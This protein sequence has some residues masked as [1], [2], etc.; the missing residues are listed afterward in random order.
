MNPTSKP[1]EE[2]RIEEFRQLFARQSVVQQYGRN[3]VLGLSAR[4]SRGAER[5]AGWLERPVV[6]LLT[7]C[8]TLVMLLAL[9][10]SSPAGSPKVSADLNPTPASI[11]I[12]QSVAEPVVEPAPPEEAVIEAAV[13][14]TKASFIIRV[15][16]FRNPLNAE[17]I[18]QALRGQTLDAKIEA[19]AGL[20][21]VTVGPVGAKDVAED[22]ARSVLNTVGLAPQILR[23]L[24]Q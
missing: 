17:R 11:D 16:S 3:P 5:I 6:L 15:G 8:F 18:V 14:G 23:L 4:F 2:Q 10:K 13:P 21:I 1:S 24:P 22:T 19:L 12:P 20:Y 7:A 9:L